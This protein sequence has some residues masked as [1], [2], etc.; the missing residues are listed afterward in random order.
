MELFS[1]C[2]VEGLPENSSNQDFKFENLR[3]VLD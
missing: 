1:F 2:K 3:S